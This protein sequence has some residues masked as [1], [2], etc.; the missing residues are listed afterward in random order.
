MDISPHLEPTREV[1]G[2]IAPWMRAVFY[3]LMAASM[4][5]LVLRIGARARLWWKG[6]PKWEQQDWRPGLRRLLVF[7][8]GQ[9]RVRRKSAGA[10]MHLL[11]FSGFLVLT[12]G[13]TLLMIA[14]AGPVYF[15]V[16]WYYLFYELVMDVFGLAFCIGCCMALHRRF[17]RRPASLGHHVSDW[18]L[19][20]LLLALGVTGFLLEAFRL[21]Y[22]QVPSEIARWSVVG[23]SLD[24]MF[25]REL[26]VE[27]TRG[28]HLG[29]WWLHAILVALFF[30]TLPVTRLLHVITGPLNIALRPERSMGALAPVSMEEIERTGQVGAGKIENF[31][32]QQLLSLDACMECGRCEDACPA[33][34]SGKPLSPKRMVVDLRHAMAGGWGEGAALHQTVTPAE[35]LWA[36][37]MCQACVQE[38]PVLVGH[39]DLISDLRRFAVAEG[40][41][42]GPSASALKQIASRH[43]PYGKPQS[44]RLDWA[45]GLKVPTV[46]ENPGFEYLVW[47]GCAASFDPRARKV[48]R[49]LVQLLGNAGV[50]YAVLGKHERCS[51][52]PA[53][54]L[55]DEFLFQDLANHNIETL[56]RHEARKIVTGCPHCYNTL[57]NEYP[58]FGGHFEV[59]HHSQLLAALLADGRLASAPNPDALV[60]LHDPC[61]LARANAEVA[62]PRAVLAASAERLHEMPRH[63]EKTSCCGAGGGRMWFEE[64]PSQ[65]VSRAR[66]QEAFHTGARTIATACPFCLNMMADAVATAAKAETVE[67]RDIA[68]LL[69]ESPAKAPETIITEIEEN[70]PARSG[71]I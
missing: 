29:C 42:A 63:G 47:I 69:L 32:R 71:S 28:L 8:L 11:I 14:H 9:K 66:A 68:E 49:A 26:S 37:T 59:Q 27:T 61:Y 36:C 54:R 43:N 19:L 64:A 57:R 4:G 33:W 53:R 39:V 16:G 5:V 67:V 52:D 35:T 25:L 41:L 22:T 21:H 34:A 40:Q 12:I 48:A 62:A 45:A 38:C 60:T 44:E 13:T 56:K 3:G 55:G 15:H 2:N 50:N 6:T 7:A 10:F 58:Q 23:W 17:F 70:E 24:R 65:R 20:A 1:F 18:Y 30:A 31:T 46:Q 51:G